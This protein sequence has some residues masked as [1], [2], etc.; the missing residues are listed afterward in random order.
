MMRP[1]K[2]RP[3]QILIPRQTLFDD[4]CRLTGSE[5]RALLAKVGV[6]PTNEVMLGRKN[7]GMVWSICASNAGWSGQ[8]SEDNET[9]Q[10]LLYDAHGYLRGRAE[11]NWVNEKEAP[12]IYFYRRYDHHSRE[13]ATA[14]DNQTGAIIITMPLPAEVRPKL[15]EFLHNDGVWHSHQPHV[16]ALLDLMKWLDE[17]YP[18]WKDPLAYWD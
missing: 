10:T 15:A 9:I 12:Y 14:T 4:D 1:T 2:S 6:V 5:K 11:V 18:L 17:N 13:D 16:Q 7:P 3:G 8:S